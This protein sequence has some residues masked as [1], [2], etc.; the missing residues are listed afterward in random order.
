MI[1]FI[2]DNIH[3]F[4]FSEKLPLDKMGKDPLDMNQYKKIFGT[5]RIPQLK[6]DALEFNPESKHIIIARNNNVG[7]CSKNAIIT[8]LGNLV[9]YGPFNEHICKSL[10]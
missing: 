2:F 5:C 4:D 1:I 9:V 7:N 8:N 6:R 3:V 10:Q